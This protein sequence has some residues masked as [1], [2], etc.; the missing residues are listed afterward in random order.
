MVARQNR[1]ASLPCG[2]KRTGDDAR[3][4]RNDNSDVS[5]VACARSPGKA[6]AGE[7]LA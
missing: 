7:K 2:D 1:G 3:S 5:A 4:S 6:V